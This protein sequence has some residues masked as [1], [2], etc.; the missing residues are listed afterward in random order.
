MGFSG[1]GFKLSPAVVHMMAALV[2]EGPGGHPYLP[3]FRFSRFAEGKPI[4]GT[5][6]DWL[7]RRGGDGAM[8]GVKDRVA[9][10]TG[11]AHGMGREIGLRLARRA[12]ARRSVTSTPTAS[13]EVAADINAAGAAR[14]P[15]SGTSPRKRAPRR[16]FDAAIERFGQLDILVNNVGGSRSGRVWEMPPAT[17]TSSSA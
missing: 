10:V 14:W 7:M 5:Y 15:S 2:T 6:G 12:G 17:G 3:T 4:R 8:P 13:S 11:A 1:H 9:V 16:L